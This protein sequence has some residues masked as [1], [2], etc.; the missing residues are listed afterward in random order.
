MN[1]D[2]KEM[3]NEFGLRLVDL[4]EEY[5]D[6]VKPADICWILIDNAVTCTLCCAPNELAGMKFILECVQ[7]GIDSY[8]QHHS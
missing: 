5:K 6:R 3:C 1:K 7:L 4:I 8:E 2:N